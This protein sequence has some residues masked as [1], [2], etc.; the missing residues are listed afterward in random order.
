MLDELI[1]TEVFYSLAYWVITAGC[2]IALLIGF[3]A[4]GLWGGQSMPFLTKALVIILTP[5]ASY[6]IVLMIKNR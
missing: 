5:V 4:Q 2:V 1:D 3:S 6:F